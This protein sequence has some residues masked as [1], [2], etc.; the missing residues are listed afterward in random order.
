MGF[1]GDVASRLR[2][3]FSRD[4]ERQALNFAK[5]ST[6]SGYPS[7]GSDLLQAYGYDIISDYLKLEHDLMCLS[8]DTRVLT[9][10]DGPKWVPIRDLAEQY[11]DKPEV[12]FYTLSF[13]CAKKEYVRSEAWRPRRTL[14]HQKVFYVVIVGETGAPEDVHTLKATA[15]HPFLLDD[16]R[17]YLRVDQLEV[18]Q[19]VMPAGSWCAHSECRHKIV[20]ILPAGEEDVYDLTV[21]GYENFAAEGVIVHNSRYVDYEEMDEY[22]LL[23]LT[24]GSLVYTLHEGWKPIRDLVG[25]PSFWVMAYDKGTKSLLPAKAENAR[26]T[27]TAGHSKPMVRVVFDDGREIVCTADHKF[28]LKDESWEEAGK[29]RQ[30]TRVMPGV[31]RMRCLNPEGLDRLYWEVHQPS[32]DSIHSSDSKRWNWIHRLVGEHVLGAT[33]GFKDVVHHINEDSLNND[34]ANLSLETRASHAR[35]HLGPI[36]NTRYFPEWTPERR[37]QYSRI[38]L[39]NKRRRGKLTSEE[40]RRKQSLALSGRVL[41]E[42]HRKA[43]GDAHRIPLDRCQ[44][45]AALSEGKTITNAAKILGVSWSTARRAVERYDLLAP[46][47]N[48]RV[49]YVERVDTREDL[50]DLSVPG[51]ENFVC[52]GVVVHNSSA[53]NIYA[54]DATQPDNSLNRTIWVKSGD[55]TVRQIG[56]DLIH[57]TLRYDEEIW[58]SARTLSKYGNDFSEILVNENGV[59]GLNFLPPPTVRRIEGP[60]G[61]LYGF[62]Q[63]FRGRFGYTPGEYQQILAQRTA[64]IASGSQNIGPQGY[65]PL[66][67]VVALEDWEVVHL[68]MKGK[69]RRSIYGFSILE[70]ARWIFKRLVLLEDTALIY[71]LQ[72][73]PERYAFYVDVGDLPP[74]EAL[75]HLNRVR[76]QHKKKSYLDPTTGKLNLKHEVLSSDSDFFVPVRGNQQGTRIEVLGAPAWQHMDDIEYFQNLLFAAILIPKG[77]LAQPDGVARSVLS[78]QDV[79][80]ARTILREQRELKNGMAKVLRVHYAALNI[81]PA[82][83]DYTVNM[84]VPSSIFELAQL[85]VR[86]ARADLATRLQAFMSEYWIYSQVLG[87]SDDD[88]QAVVQ[89]REE[90][91]ERRGRFAALEQTTVQRA[92]A[93]ANLDI[94]NAEMHNQLSV[95]QPMQAAASAQLPP[96]AAPAGALPQGQP[97][98]A[99][100]QPQPKQEQAPAF[101]RSLSFTNTKPRRLYGMEEKLFEGHNKLSNDEAGHKLTALLRSD[102]AQARRIMELRDMVQELAFSQ[103]A[104]LKQ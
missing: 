46:E 78:N 48:H 51:F 41:S 5:G 104:L 91:A 18:G 29:L 23:C 67:R 4:K 44:V 65:S 13:D 3:F 19:S 39:G 49:L 7:S 92:S 70:A 59:V 86:T 54:D 101:I 12:S 27:L 37:L 30:G 6:S 61:E 26:L 72:R 57:R 97:Q 100:P 35:H 34:P 28:M 15:N 74:H 16:G 99:A 45:E 85:E 22:P 84:T 32:I 75:A 96:G 98:P 11:K 94:Q 43:I 60:R 24:G 66:D 20:A 52:N 64:S 31:L 81:D 83:I 77:Y 10:N 50:Y 73:A 47:A 102:E 55:E 93:Q 79:R 53:L 80:F 9:L 58:E 82:Q 87:L 21:P 95:I 17:T 56:D 14:C 63:D 89:Q 25:L 68:R 62:I 40:G 88:I 2:G 71:R 33:R 38:L 8:G 103:R 90:D 42:S 76:Q 36:D 69:Q 1:L